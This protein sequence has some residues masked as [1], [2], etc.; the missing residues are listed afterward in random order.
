MGTLTKMDMVEDITNRIG[1]DKNTASEG[2]ETVI[3]IIKQSLGK[4]EPVSLSGF[5]KFVVREKGPRMGRNPKT[6]EQMEIKKRRVVTF[7]L[8]NVLRKKLSE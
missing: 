2:I 8:S 5:G 4:K 6:G 1:I 7:H 3:E